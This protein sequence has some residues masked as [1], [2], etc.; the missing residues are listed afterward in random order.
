MDNNDDDDAYQ[1][2]E[3]DSDYTPPTRVLLYT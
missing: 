3:I 1:F 2:T